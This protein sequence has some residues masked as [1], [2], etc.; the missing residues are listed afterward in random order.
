MRKIPT[1]FVRD[2]ADRRLVTDIVNPGCEWVLEGQ[3]VATQK[4]DGTCCMLDDAGA[5][6]ARREVKPGKNTPA[7]YVPIQ[8]DP[9]TGKTVG[10]E[11]IAQSAFAKFHTQ[12][13]EAAH[14]REK[15]LMPGTYELVGP[16]VNGNPE[17]WDRHGLIAHRDAAVV[18]MP[19]QITYS[20][21]RDLFET[22]LAP[23]GHEGI[24]WHHPDG[25]RFAKLK[26]RDFSKAA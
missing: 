11:P 1:L 3:G 18:G 14:D 13:L 7:G 4:Y 19:R 10:W 8:T 6:W 21:L 22:V 20:T 25:R 15:R 24:V 26:V 16:K 2:T 17:R 9:V 5:W 12:A 23:L